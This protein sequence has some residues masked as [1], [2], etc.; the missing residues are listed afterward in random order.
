MSQSRLRYILIHARPH[1]TFLPFV[2]VKFPV[3]GVVVYVAASLVNKDEHT[4]SGL[5]HLSLHY[6][7][8]STELYICG[9]TH[10]WNLGQPIRSAQ[11]A[12]RRT[13][14]YAYLSSS[15]ILT[16]FNSKFSVGD[17]LESSRI[18]FT[19]PDATKQC[20]TSFV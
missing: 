12:S 2:T 15:S 7:L 9:H 17:S 8:S 4:S 6:R 5:A 16:M 19:P 20:E 11:D 3:I 10:D 13:S 1:V 18:K 14:G